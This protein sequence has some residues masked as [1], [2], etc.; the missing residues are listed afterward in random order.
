M[1]NK[2]GFSCKKCPNCCIFNCE[3]ET[4]IVFYWEK[5]LL[6]KIAKDRNLSLRF[7]KLVSIFDGEDMFIY[8]YKWLIHGKCPFLS[9][10]LCSI[11]EIKPISCKMFPLGIKIPENQIYVSGK[12]RW[13][14]ENRKHV[15]IENIHKIF[16]EFDLAIKVM[17]MLKNFFE[18]AKRRGWSIII[19]K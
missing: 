6:E 11:H 5:E 4:P 17:L 13:V 16:S 8:I 10:N 18:E 12:C 2:I 3:E 14:L 7:K 9:G 1:G 15:K 19:S